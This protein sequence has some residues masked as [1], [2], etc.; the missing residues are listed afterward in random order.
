[1]STIH[2]KQRCESFN[3]EIG[4]AMPKTFINYHYNLGECS[5]IL[6]YIVPDFCDDLMKLQEATDAPKHP[7]TN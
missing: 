6:Q 4:Q 2:I 1:M 7:I 3:S 5:I